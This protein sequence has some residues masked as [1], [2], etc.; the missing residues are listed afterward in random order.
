MLRNLKSSWNFERESS[1][2]DVPAML[3]MCCAASLIWSFKGEVLYV[4]ALIV[5]LAEVY[6]MVLMQAPTERH[7]R[8]IMQ[9]PSS[10][11]VSIITVPRLA[12][13]TGHAGCASAHS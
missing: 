1:A 6:G 7:Q 2:V 10:R 12:A 3:Y 11:P 8:F 9:C 13:C 4:R 5:C